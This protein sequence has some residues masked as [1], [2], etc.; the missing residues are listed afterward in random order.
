MDKHK[1]VLQGDFPIRARRVE[2]EWLVYS[3]GDGRTHRFSGPVAHVFGM[4]WQ[5]CGAVMTAEIFIEV[6]NKTGIVQLDPESLAQYID[7]LA[8]L[9]LVK[10]V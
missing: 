8:D 1:W 3:D 4:L 9:N 10:F 2:N 5:N 7:S 6:I